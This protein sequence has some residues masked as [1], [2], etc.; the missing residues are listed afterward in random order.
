MH[1]SFSD[2]TVLDVPDMCGYCEIST[3]GSH[4]SHCPLYEPTKESY[5]E[6]GIRLKR[7]IDSH[8]EW[9]AKLL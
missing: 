7:E 8:P 9:G 1:Y 5:A 4:Q 2:G 6:F 3:S